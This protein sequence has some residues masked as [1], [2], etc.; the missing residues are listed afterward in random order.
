MYNIQNYI[1]AYR[2]YNN[3][4]SDAQWNQK[5]SERSSETSYGLYIFL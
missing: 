1:E 3:I 5:K 2:T 4:Y